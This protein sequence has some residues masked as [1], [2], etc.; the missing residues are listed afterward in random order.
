MAVKTSEDDIRDESNHALISYGY[1][2]IVYAVDNGAKIINCSWGGNSFSNTEQAVIDYAVSKGALIVAAAGNDNS[3]DNF[4]PADYQGVLS[5]AAT[6][7]LD[8][9]AY[10]SNYGTHIDVCS[11][12]VEIYSTWKTNPYYISADGTSLASPIVAGLAAL[13]ANQFPSYTGLQIGEQIRVNTDNIDDK[14]PNYTQLL[15]TGRINAYQSLINS[16]SKSVRISNTNFSEV[17]D[18]DGLYESGETIDISPTF[19]NYLNSLSNLIVTLESDNSNVQIIKAGGTIS[20]LSTLQTI[21]TNSD[22]FS[23]KINSNAADN[24]D[25]KFK[26]VY[27]TDNYQDFEWITVLINPVYDIQTTDNLSITF[28]SNGSIGFD[29]Y[30]TNLKGTGIK[31]KEGPNLLFEGALLYGTSDSTIVNCARDVD[32]NKDKD[33]SIVNPIK[34]I[35]SNPN[36]DMEKFA[37]FNDE[38]ANPKSLGVETKFYSYS[39]KNIEDADYMFVRYAM[40]NKSTDTLKNFYIGQFFD[41]DINDTSYYDDMVNY[42]SLNGF[43]YVYDDNGDPVTTNIGLAFLSQGKQGFFAMDAE[44]ISNPT[45]AY[46][47]FTDKEKWISLTSGLKYK[48]SGPNDIS[49]V[50]S[51][52]PF[53]LLPNVNHNF[54]FL[55]ACGDNLESLTQNVLKAK[56]KYNNVLTDIKIF[57]E[58]TPTQ[59][60]LYQNYP[61]PFNPATTIDYSIP[62]VMDVKF[63]SITNT[64]LIIYDILGREVATL[65]NAKQNPGSYSVIFDAS[66]L[67]SGIYFYKLSYGDLVLIKKMIFL[68]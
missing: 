44:G 61:N 5:V 23:I 63:A 40:N 1:E 34:T 27:Q 29:D 50:I 35:S 67:S 56:Q 64:R 41:F 7:S 59:F 21:E 6:D 38:N 68:K 65:V 16:S 13:V 8:I 22:F 25:V 31:Y 17:G 60:E 66:N 53:T 57:S 43:G 48:S 49:L 33:F 26:I 20:S 10:F 39:F 28:T 4:Y 2:G 52:G 32:G 51:G 15:G 19:T 58:E 14:N 42:D 46:D 37:E 45:I 3:S 55:I 9:R 12:G 30:P 18:G 36:I 11:P 62:N 24:I 54:D 47:G